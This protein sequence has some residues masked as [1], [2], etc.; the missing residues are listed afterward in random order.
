MSS[1]SLHFAAGARPSA[2]D[3]R[4]LALSSGQ[5]S[6][7]I[8]PDNEQNGDGDQGASWVELLSRGLTFDLAGL[9]PGQA[10]DAAK[11]AY[12]FGLNDNFTTDSY[13]TLSLTPG[14]HLAGGETMFPILQRLAG[15]AA[16]LTNLPGAKAVTWHP[17]RSCCEAGYFRENVTRW[18]QGGAF[19]GLGLTALVP[20]SDGGLRSEG[21]ALFIGQEL[22]MMPEL[23]VDRSEG[24]KMALRLLHWL[25]ENG[26]VHSAQLITGPDGEPLRLEPAPLQGL[27]KVTRVL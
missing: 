18:I 5:F 13:D 8:D 11:P 20:T 6:I 4:A 21:L 26:R 17:A 2:R 27:V 19:P 14:P 3:I 22:H 25:V 7:S 10:L 1:V 24:A 12:L 16:T 23:V 15:L 9:S